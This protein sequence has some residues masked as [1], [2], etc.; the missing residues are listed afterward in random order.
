[1]VAV[2][3]QADGFAIVNGAED[4]AKA[5]NNVAKD[6][7]SVYK[8]LERMLTGSAWGAV[9]VATGAIVLP[10]AANHN[11]LPFAIPGV[12]T[13]EPAP[14]NIESMPPPHTPDIGPDR[15]TG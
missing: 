6:N 3:N 9:I 15:A 4:L 14:A 7:P 10:I 12:T 8:T 1:M 13:P 11:L 2:I 5:L